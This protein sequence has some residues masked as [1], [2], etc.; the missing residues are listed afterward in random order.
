MN[1]DSD[2][3]FFQA[4]GNVFK[5]AFPKEVVVL[6]AESASEAQSWVE[7]LGEALELESLRPSQ[8]LCQVLLLTYST[9]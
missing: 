5:A 6:R 3:F 9:H 8:E 4:Y 2:F 7:V 1:H